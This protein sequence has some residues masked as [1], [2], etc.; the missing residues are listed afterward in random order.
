MAI[1]ARSNWLSHLNCQAD[2][3]NRFNSRKRV[4]P[5][6]EWTW[7]AGIEK[8]SLFRWLAKSTINYALRSLNK[9]IPWGYQNWLNKH[10]DLLWDARELLEDDLSKLLF[11]NM[12]IL[13]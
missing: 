8:K 11:D 7:L 5:E 9:P 13:R 3:Y 10:A 4:D 12:L 2:F 6:F 1:Q